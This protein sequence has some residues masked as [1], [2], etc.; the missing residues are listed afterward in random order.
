MEEGYAEQEQS[1]AFPMLTAERL[2][3]LGVSLVIRGGEETP[4]I[5]D[6]GNVILDV[7]GEGEI[8]DPAELAVELKKIIGVV[9]HGLFVD[10]TD[11]V[12]VAGPE[13][14]R[15]MGRGSGGGRPS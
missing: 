1:L 11:T 12:I 4:Y 9:E 2:T 7:S 15:A 14:P 3:E 6:N 8:N 5:T 13:G 10:M